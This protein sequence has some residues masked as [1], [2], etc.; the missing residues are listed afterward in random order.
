M[1]MCDIQ[2][3]SLRDRGLWDSIQALSSI[4]SHG[5]SFASALASPGVDPKIALVRDGSSALVIPF[6]E[7]EWLGRFDIA[8]LLSVSGAW[9][10]RPSPHLVEAWRSYAVSRRWV[11]GFLQFEPETDMTGLPD[12]QDGNVVLLLDVSPND[13]LDRVS[14]IIRRKIR[15]ADAIG[16]TLIEDRDILAAHLHPLYSG[17]LERTGASSAYRMAEAGLR[18]MALSRSHLVLGAAIGGEVIAI[19]VFPVSGARAEY[20]IGASTAQGRDATAWLMWQAILR[21]KATGVNTLNL[22]GGVRPGDGLHDFKLKFGA[23]PRPLHHVKQIYDA[24]AYEAFCRAE[25]VAPDERWFPA[26]RAR[27][28]REPAAI[29]SPG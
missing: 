25:H 13:P 26:Y 16:M 22:G 8:T 21:L 14:A 4:P 11:A 3:A 18:N 27:S 19:M 24:E 29:G 1:M 5:F 28:A 9:M 17:T 6:F 23:V 12:V 20:H 7:R 2:V 15:R 10:N